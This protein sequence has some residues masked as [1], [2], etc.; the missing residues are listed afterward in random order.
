M[1]ALK[2]GM[3]RDARELRMTPGTTHCHVGAITRTMG[4]RILSVVPSTITFFRPILSAIN[5]P[6]SWKR[7]REELCI[8]ERSPTTAI[9]APST[10]RRYRDHQSRQRELNTW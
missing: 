4:P 9:G 6:G 5:P 10:S 2:A 3:Y 1:M 7:I 8:V